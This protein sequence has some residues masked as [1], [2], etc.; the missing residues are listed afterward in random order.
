[1]KHIVVISRYPHSPHFTV[2]GVGYRTT[3]QAEK[4]IKLFEARAKAI[5]DVQERFGFDRSVA[6]D[7]LY[8][9]AEVIIPNAF[10]ND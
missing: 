2:E 7:K 10:F 3:A 4:Y 5:D 1:M 9:V 6:S 8:A